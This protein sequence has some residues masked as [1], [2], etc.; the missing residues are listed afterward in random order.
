MGPYRRL[1]FDSG[2]E[3]TNSAEPVFHGVLEITRIV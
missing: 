3:V 1:L 2:P